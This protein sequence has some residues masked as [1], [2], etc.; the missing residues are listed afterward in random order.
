MWYGR[1]LCG[2]VAGGA[3]DGS[4]GGIIEPTVAYSLDWLL[5]DGVGDVDVPIGLVPSPRFDFEDA[6]VLNRNTFW[7]EP[8]WGEIN[9]FCLD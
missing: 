4:G 5:Y 6:D 7:R 1:E 9:H 3:V 8:C 2:N